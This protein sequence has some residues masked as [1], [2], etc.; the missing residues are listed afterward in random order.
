MASKKTQ[1]RLA[2]TVKAEKKVEA[3]EASRTEPRTEAVTKVE[4]KPKPET[5]R[6]EKEKA[7]AKRDLV[8]KD[9]EMV[10]RMFRDAGLEV[11]KRTGWHKVQG[12]D[13]K[14]VYVSVGG[15][16]VHLSGFTVTGHL[17]EQLSPEKAKE[18]H[19]GSV[20]GVLHL[21]RNDTNAIRAAVGDIIDRMTQVDAPVVTVK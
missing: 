9:R 8:A 1:E 2:R 20:R 6:A 18:R 21:D 10:L 4:A 16:Q 5:K 15:P 11:E 17:V 7:E 12:R 13:R 3:R 14:R 19:L